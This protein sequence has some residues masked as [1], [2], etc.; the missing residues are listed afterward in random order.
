MGEGGAGD[1]CADKISKHRE[2]VV[3]QGGHRVEVDVVD[4]NI[5]RLAEGGAGHPNRPRGQ[6]KVGCIIVCRVHERRAPRHDE[7]QLLSRAD[8]I[9][10]FPPI[11]PWVSMHIR[12]GVRV[13]HQVSVIP[14]ATT[15][16]N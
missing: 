9:S 16:T 13:C 4:A 11:R 3:R 15:F 5:R 12:H 2:R 6:V 8:V 1:A 10:A 14:A 7:V